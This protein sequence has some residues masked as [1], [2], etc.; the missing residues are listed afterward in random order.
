MKDLL[1][2]LADGFE[3]VE[4]LTVVDIA[5]RAGLDVVTTSI[6]DNSKKVKGTHG[7]YVLADTTLSDINIE[8]YRALYIPG[9]QPGAT[10]LQKEKR[11]VQTVE[12]FKEN[13][14]LVAAICAG[15][16]VFDEAG[17]IRDGEYTC[18]PGVENRLKTKNPKDLPVYLD[19]NV[20]TS[21]GPATA[22][23]LALEIVKELL[24]EEKKEEIA[25][26]FLFNKLK[27]FIKEDIV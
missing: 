5:R 12:I 19:E 27:N 13:N 18:Y 22:I 3:E 25:E 9:G 1:V 15:P 24:G 2:F 20:M 21:M 4:A 11:V 8:E 26:A 23:V 10:N 14:K 6:T 7:I 16:Q 17:T